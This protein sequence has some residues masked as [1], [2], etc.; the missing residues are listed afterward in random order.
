MQAVNRVSINRITIRD[1]AK[2]A[3][4][5]IQTVS[6]VVNDH[7]DVADHTRERVQD[8]IADLRYHPNG[9]ARSLITK[10]SQTLGVVA[11]A[12][13]LFGPSQLLTG[14]E[15]QATELG[16]HIMLQVVDETQTSEYDRAA[17]ALLTKSVDGVIWAYPELNGERER[18]LHQRVQHHAPV[19][20]L[21]MAP[22][23]GSAVISVDN[24][25][26]ARMATEHLIAR[27]Y[28]NIGIITGMSKLWSAQQRRLGWQD[29]L[30]AA[31]L[32]CSSKQIVEGAWSATSGHSA[33]T[34]LFS[35]FPKLDA[36]FASNDQMAL[37]AMK[38]AHKMKRNIPRD[39]GVVGFDNTPESAYFSPALTTVHHD[40]IELGRLAVR[41]LHRVIQ[42][43]RED[44]A[45]PEPASL[46]LQPRLVIRESA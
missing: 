4:V 15:Q 16:W 41:E 30:V 13:H 28:Q 22:Q 31:K 17:N 6:R 44:K 42:L 33:M 45:S 12:F 46:V 3:G 2:R 9:V 38:V 24:R 36:V 29:A 11:S 14:I 26:G 37:G 27:G 18:K 23:H 25:L 43:K 21:S 1:V 20:F 39:L 40:L 35:Q 7:P 34:K 5:S 19:V 8:V 10:S 32:P